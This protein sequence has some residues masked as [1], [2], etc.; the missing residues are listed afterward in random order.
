MCKAQETIY[1]APEQKG[2]FYITHATIHVGNG[3]IINDGTIKVTNG[4][5]ESVGQQHFSIRQTM[6][7][8][9]DAKGK[10]VYPGLI[11]SITNLGLKEV[12]SGVRGSNDY[13]ELGDIN[14]SIRSIV[15]YNTD[16]KVINTL[17][18]NG[19]L[20]ANVIPQDEE[21]VSSTLITGTSSV[22]QLDAWNWEDAAYKMDG[23]M[24]F[25]MP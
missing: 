7:K 3:Q 14:P 24:H 21:S 5:I 10:Q 25:N 8:V 11:S 19:I 23:Q 6:A 2:T 15:A 13:D 18:T 12:S 1:P 16:S 9:I 20:L 4:K 17:R 22:V